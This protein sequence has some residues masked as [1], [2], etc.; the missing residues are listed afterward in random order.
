MATWRSQ[1]RTINLE[2][3]G[4]NNWEGSLTLG[5]SEEYS[6]QTQFN[7]INYTPLPFSDQQ[8]LG[9]WVVKSNNSG[10]LTITLF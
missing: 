6:V 8:D 3:P 9:D 7:Y 10:Q 1:G 5:S 4:D 2:A